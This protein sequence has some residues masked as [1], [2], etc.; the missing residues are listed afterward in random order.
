M[1]RLI[2]FF[3]AVAAIAYGMSWLADRPGNLVIDWQGYEVTVPLMNAVIALL[4][5]VGGSILFWSILQRLLT[6]PGQIL[7]LLRR[8]KQTKGMDALSTGIIAVGA[9]DRELAMRYAQQARRTLPHE[10]LTDLLRAQAAQLSGD[11]IT[12]HRIYEAMLGDPNTELLGLRGLFLEAKQQNADEAARQFAERAMRINPKL[13]WPIAALFDIQCR[14][15]RWAEALETLAVAQ[16]SGHITKDVAKRRR[17]VLLTA[18]AQRQEDQD[19]DEAMRLA[20]EA[21]KLAPDL[22]P[23]GE[24]A[25]RLLASRGHTAKAASILQATWKAAPHPDL[26]LAYAFARPGDSPKDRLRR[27]KELTALRLHELEAPIAVAVAAVEAHDW[28][29]AR[30]ALRPLL[31]RRLTKRVCTLMARIEGGEFGDRGKVRE[32]I[33]RAVNA[34]RDPAWIADG[35]VSDHWAPVSPVTG[36]LD[37]FEWRTPT[38]ALD[39]SR[40]ALMMEELVPLA[41]AAGGLLDDAGMGQRNGSNGGHAKST[42]AVPE[43]DVEVVE[44]EP[45][46][47]PA[48]GSGPSAKDFAVSTGRAA[49][50]ATG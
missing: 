15:G 47:G 25:G 13:E 17:A 42:A 16:R 4:V 24:I 29:A 34:P 26:A 40:Q 35:V 10:P 44:V 30:H 43:A 22:V 33:A 5:L 3:V 11:E 28:Q 12:A 37:A 36:R 6:S 18:Q 19:I 38:E 21:H 48:S 49:R 23:A 20:T 31:D 27:V 9:G 32:W 41:A 2:A 50:T 39:K 45:E 8:R 14:E 7:D 1:I 46:G